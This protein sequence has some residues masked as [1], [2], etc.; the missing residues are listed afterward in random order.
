M[1]DEDGAVTGAGCLRD[2]GV[3]DIGTLARTGLDGTPGERRRRLSSVLRSRCPTVQVRRTQTS[4]P[5]RSVARRA[6][7]GRT[8]ATL[9]QVLRGGCVCCAIRWRRRA[10]KGCRDPLR[11]A[12]CAQSP[13]RPLLEATR[14]PRQLRPLLATPRCSPLSAT[15]AQ[16]AVA[17]SGDAGGW[18]IHWSPRGFRPR[19]EAAQHVTCEPS[20][21]RGAAQH[22]SQ[23]RM[24]MEWSRG[25]VVFRAAASRA[26]DFFA[27]RFL[28]LRSVPVATDRPL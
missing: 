3:L 13:T 18:A 14:A 16:K 22:E 27:R 9:D 2:S 1:K 12:M 28:R 8:W 5:S 20:A 10:P 26:L 15:C 25:L 6:V 19:G 7:P 23:C 11:E 17:P 21:H 4:S 24:R